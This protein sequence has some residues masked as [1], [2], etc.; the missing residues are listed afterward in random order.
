MKLSVSVQALAS[1][2]VSCI[3]DTN[4]STSYSAFVN[5]MEEL[6]KLETYFNQIFYKVLSTSWL[7]NHGSIFKSWRNEEGTIQILRSFSINRLEAKQCRQLHKCQ[8]DV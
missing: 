1:I 5:I 3:S 8:P 7:R 4:C 2:M 6:N